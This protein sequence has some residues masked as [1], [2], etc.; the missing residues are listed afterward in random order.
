MPTPLCISRKGWMTG[1]G[2]AGTREGGGV[3]TPSLFSA[4]ALALLSRAAHSR[5]LPSTDRWRWAESHGAPAP[6]L[7]AFPH[8]PC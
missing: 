8:G 7:P 1:R 5:L 2:K 3:V 6:A 4:P